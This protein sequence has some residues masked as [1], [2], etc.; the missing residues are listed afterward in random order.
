MKP[1]G[2]GLNTCHRHSHAAVSAGTKKM[3]TKISNSSVNEYP[4]RYT[5]N[6]ILTAAMINHSGMNSAIA[7][8]VEPAPP[9]YRASKK[10]TPSNINPPTMINAVRILPPFNP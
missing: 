6:H 4:A 9:R 7:M 1:T 3:T 5:P 8:R 10:H 2:G